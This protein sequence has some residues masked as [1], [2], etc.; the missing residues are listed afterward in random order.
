M[1]NIFPNVPTVDFTPRTLSMW[2][3]SEDRIGETINIGGTPVKKL[4]TMD[5]NIPDQSFANII[6][7]SP[8]TQV[9]KNFAKN[10]PCPHACKGCFNDS[11]VKNPIMSYEEVF[12]VLN[13]GVEL[14]LESI[15]FLG[16]GELLA[17]P[18]LFKIL[19]ALQ[20]KKIAIAIFT[21]GAILGSDA[22]SYHYHDISSEELVSRLIDY[23]IRFLIGG[24]S[25]DPVVENKNIPTRNSLLKDYHA[26]R[27]IAIERLCAEGLNN[28][29]NCQRVSLITAPVNPQTIDGVF[30]I[31]QWGTERNIPVCVTV[32]MIS[33]KGHRLVK[34]QQELIFEK[35]YQ[36]LSVNIYSYL[37][38]KGIMSLE[39]IEHEGV[40]SYAGTTPCNQLTHGLY[41]HYDGEVMMCPGN[42]TPGF[43]VHPNVRDS[44]LIDIWLNS[45]NY[46]INEFNNYCVKD[47]ISIPNNFYY[48]VLSRIR[49]LHG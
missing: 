43:I 20:D 42:D 25:F 45:K 28:D 22:L 3:L 23:D 30:E 19:D 27:N 37:I 32:T 48:E 13:Q 38:S 6:N 40:S 16:P 35:K 24:C 11:K 21:K 14:G 18:D 4:L 12:D 39:Q 17:N 34:D 33:G 41:I 47:G 49:E 44:K 31:F 8:I 2:Q 5:V 46:T 7:D 29:P 10:Y 9:K 1:N 26:A 15:K 36:D